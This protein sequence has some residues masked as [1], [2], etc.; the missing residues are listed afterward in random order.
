MVTYGGMSKKPITVPTGP[1]IFKVHIQDCK[2][3]FN[4]LPTL[5]G[6]SSPRMEQI[7]YVFYGSYARAKNATLPFIV[8]TITTF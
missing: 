4:I 6:R 5:I 7:T 3:S 8:H 1:L 2:Y